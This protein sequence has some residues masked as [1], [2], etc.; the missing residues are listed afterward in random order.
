MIH[1]D[2]VNGEVRFSTSQS[3]VEVH[4]KLVSVVHTHGNDNLFPRWAFGCHIDPRLEFVYFA[5]DGLIDFFDFS[6]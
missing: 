6:V 2:K 4:Y 3:M 5:K 1:A